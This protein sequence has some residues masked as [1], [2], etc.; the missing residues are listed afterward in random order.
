MLR[1]DGGG[2]NPRDTSVTQLPGNRELLTGVFRDDGVGS[3][4]RPERPFR[5]V[6]PVGF[7]AWH[8]LNTEIF[9]ALRSNVFEIIIG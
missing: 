3:R 2:Y 9:Y 7:Q 4:N 5:I 1:G 6:I 8:S